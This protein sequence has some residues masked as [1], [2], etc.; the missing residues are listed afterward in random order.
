MKKILLFLPVVAA[1]WSCGRTGE[2]TAGSVL[3]EIDSTTLDAHLSV[4][5]SNSFGGRKPFSD[6]DALT[7]NYLK[8]QFEKMGLEPGNN[9]SYFQEVP[10]VMIEGTTSEEMKVEGN[11]GNFALASGEEFVAYTERVVDKV[12]VTA[13]EL[14]FCGFGI[15]APEYGWNDYAGIDMKG[16]T[17]VVLVN[18]PGFQSGDTTLFKGDIMTYY[19]RWTYKYEEAARQGAEGV[20]IV[21]STVPAGYPW[22]VVQSSWSS[23][24]L[25]LEMPD[26]NMSKSA[27]QGWITRDAAIKLFKASDKQIDDFVG[28][29]R[30]RDFKPFS[31]GLK[32]SLSI[33]NK[34]EKN[35][36]R[37]VVAKITGSEKPNEYI[38]YS[39]H[40]D[41]LG[42]G[43]PDQQGDSIYNGANDNASGTAGLLAIA[44][45]F[46]KLKE[47]PKRTVVF[48]AVTAE[49]QGLLGSEF[50]ARNPIYPPAKT[51]AN[52]NM[53]GLNGYGPM[54]D[55]TV[56]G[57]GQSELDDYAE[58]IASQQGRYIKPDPDPGKGYFFRSD[59]FNFA[60]VGIPAIFAAGDYE[61]MTKGK[62]YIAQQ[63]EEYL[64]KRYH[65][66]G[67]NYDENYLLGGVVQDATLF[68]QLGY[69]L[70]NTAD[71]PQWKPGSEF[72]SI[73]EA[74]ISR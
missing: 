50:Y 65:M 45:A 67:D 7:V 49:E 60:K 4:L 57:H 14:V 73:R 74:S 43:K 53:D 22:M 24:K 55:L 46:T 51:V 40:W 31:L 26:G 33:D 71:W 72:K 37:N 27:M 48:L 11:G 19:G 3:P 10:M 29:S 15:V 44:E 18:D 25:G 6:G 9:D 64:A 35:T 68:F 58:R 69:Q 59:H 52:I 42:V 36:S 63:K 62:D 21:H 13:S 12:E 17:A 2:Q 30:S 38:I 61:H 20:L 66:P 28:M 8:S 56:I 16:K 54:K 70:A 47:K 1:V 39:A 5:A 41:H 32:V 23:G 34:I